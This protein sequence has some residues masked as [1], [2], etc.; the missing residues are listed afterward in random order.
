VFALAA[1]AGDGAVDEPRVEGRQGVVVDAQSLGDAGPKTL[2]HHVGTLGERQEGIEVVSALE[3]EHR[4][5]LAPLPHPVAELVCEGVAIRPLD[6]G[7]LCAV[8]GEQHG[9]HGACDP[10]GEIEYANTVE[11]AGH[12]D[13]LKRER[14]GT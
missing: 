10:P 11:N 7:D 5:A 14:T 3:V 2:H 1:I 13:S 6:A 8:V 9:R 12:E 4:A